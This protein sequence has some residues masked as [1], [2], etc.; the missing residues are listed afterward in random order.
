MIIKYTQFEK[1][2]IYHSDIWYFHLTFH[3]HLRVNFVPLFS[4]LLKAQFITNFALHFFSPG[5]LTLKSPVHWFLLCSMPNANRT[6]ESFYR[7]PLTHSKTRF[8]FFRQ[9]NSS[10][11]FLVLSTKKWNKKKDREKKHV[12]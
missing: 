1:N 8:V 6:A 10:L 12:A 4:S 7:I 2:A 11:P 9:L 3:K 5:A